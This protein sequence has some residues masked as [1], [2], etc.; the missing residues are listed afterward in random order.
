MTID[1]FDPDVTE[2]RTTYDSVGAP[3]TEVRRTRVRTPSAGWWV[4]G[5]VAVV[6]IFAL[7]W[8]LA[9]PAGPTAADQAAVADRAVVNAADQGRAEGIAEGAQS[10]QTAAALAQ[11]NAAAMSQ[12]SAQAAI[13]AS[14]NN[15]QI[16]AD[17][18][19]AAR[20]QAERAANQAAASAAAA[21]NASAGGNPPDADTPQ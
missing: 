6:A 5:L 10:A 7:V 11:G 17:R 15:L 20:A 4:A 16:E 12:N 9:R 13:Q 8:L 18:A 21:R 1:P 2:V 14:Q 3:V 19:A